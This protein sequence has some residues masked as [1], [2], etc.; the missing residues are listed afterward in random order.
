MSTHGNKERDT[1]PDERTRER[2]A[3]ERKVVAPTPRDVRAKA[4]GD[5]T[6]DDE[7]SDPP[8]TGTRAP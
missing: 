4:E 2:S 1:R 3:E 7:K 6:E 8:A 5:K